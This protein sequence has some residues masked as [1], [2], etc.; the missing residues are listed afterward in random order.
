MRRWLERQRMIL[1]Y[2]M[3]KQQ[4]ELRYSSKHLGSLS[5]LFKI[6]MFLVFYFEWIEN[7]I[8]CF[9]LFTQFPNNRIKWNRL[10][11]RWRL[12]FLPNAILVYSIVQIWLSD[13]KSSNSSLLVRSKHMKTLGYFSHAS[14]IWNSRTGRKIVL[15][16]L[17][18]FSPTNIVWKCQNPYAMNEQSS[19]K[20]FL[21]LNYIALHW[22]SE[23]IQRKYLFLTPQTMNQPS[24]N[25]R[26]EW[27]E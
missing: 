24:I 10:L 13:R 8:F 9:N 18:A 16:V 14:K 15:L 22:R 27:T 2:C 5:T 23:K 21:L 1:F 11:V 3:S 25:T 7:P 6:M 20:R 12:Q 17:Y 4:C 19:T 26:K